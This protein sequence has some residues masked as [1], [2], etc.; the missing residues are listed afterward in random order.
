MDIQLPFF[1]SKPRDGW[2]RI[3]KIKTLEDLYYCD[4]RY[5]NHVLKDFIGQVQEEKA[6]KVMARWERTIPLL[7]CAMKNCTYIE[8][9]ILV[10]WRPHEFDMIMQVDSLKNR[11]QKQDPKR[12]RN[13]ILNYAIK[14]KDRWQKHHGVPVFVERPVLDV[15]LVKQ[16]LKRTGIIK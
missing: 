8:A 1:R 7:A 11:Y 4:N 3:D 2:K 5:I 14:D 12:V 6:D 15:K 13:M 10:N 16:E 9:F